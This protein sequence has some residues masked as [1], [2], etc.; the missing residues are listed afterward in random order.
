MIYC[1]KEPDEIRKLFNDLIKRYVDLVSHKTCDKD[2][3]AFVSDV[4]NFVERMSTDLDVF[5]NR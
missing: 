1:A 5:L 3:C 4:S 2:K